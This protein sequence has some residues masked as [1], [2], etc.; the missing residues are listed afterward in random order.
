MKD[1]LT[2]ISSNQVS[3]IQTHAILC[4]ATVHQVYSN[5]VIIVQLQYLILQKYLKIIQWYT[6]RATD[7]HKMVSD[8]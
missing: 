4:A 1:S 3:Y 8:H 5:R 2:A 7:C 6:I